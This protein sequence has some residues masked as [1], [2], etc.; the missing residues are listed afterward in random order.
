[1]LVFRVFLCKLV[2]FSANKYLSNISGWEINNGIEMSIKS[3][4]KCRRKHS[5]LLVPE[6]I[7]SNT[8]RKCTCEGKIS[9]WTLILEEKL[10]GITDHKINKMDKMFNRLEERLNKIEEKQKEYKAAIEYTNELA[11]KAQVTANKI[12]EE[13]KTAV[14]TSVNNVERQVKELGDKKYNAGNL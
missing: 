5:S 2:S 11:D 7:E 9:D 1:M 4:G 6:E 10:E 14:C 3:K 12:S 13:L 8:V